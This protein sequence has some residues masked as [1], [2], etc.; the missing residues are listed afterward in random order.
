M[1]HP[2]EEHSVFQIELLDEIVNETYLGLF[3]ADFPSFSGFDDNY[4]CDDCTNT[5]LC[6]VCAEI[7]VALQGVIFPTGE[8]VD[9]AVYETEVLYISAAPS[10]PSIEQPPSL[11]LKPLLGNMKY[12]YLER[13]E[14]IRVIIS[15]NLDFDQEN[16]LLHVL[17]KDKKAIGWTL[18]ASLLLAPPCVCTGFYLRIGQK[19]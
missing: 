11:E 12:A 6:V 15:S 1:K 17:K 7:D 8:V 3:L 18:A 9:E 5:N 13:N 14:K 16:K 2:L 19:Q 4:S 10:T